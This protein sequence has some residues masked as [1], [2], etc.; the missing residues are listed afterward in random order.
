MNKFMF[1]ILTMPVMG[2]IT[3]FIAFSL[4][5]WNVDRQIL[6]SML[7]VVIMCLWLVFAFI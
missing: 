4:T 6:P 5:K 2:L 1:F 3:V 7:G